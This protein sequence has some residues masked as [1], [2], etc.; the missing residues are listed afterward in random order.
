MKSLRLSRFVMKMHLF[1][2]DRR[3]KSQAEFP[4]IPEMDLTFVFDYPTIRDM[5]GFVLSQL[6]DA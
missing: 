1:P 4:E 6:P 5:T 2:L 3:H